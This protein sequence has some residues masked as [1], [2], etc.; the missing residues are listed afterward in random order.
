[1][2]ELYKKHRPRFPWNESDCVLPLTR[3][4]VHAVLMILGD[5]EQALITAR[6][7]LENRSEL[8]RQLDLVAWNFEVLQSAFLSDGTNERPELY[9]LEVEVT[10]WG[11]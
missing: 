11:E 2:L 9:D 5:V 6:G 10:K 8:L 4:D 1:M 3:G 7:A